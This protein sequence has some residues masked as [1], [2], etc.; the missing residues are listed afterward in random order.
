MST[1]TGNILS[2]TQRTGRPRTRPVPKERTVELCYGPTVSTAIEALAT[3]QARELA[4][5]GTRGDGK[6]IGVLGGMLEHARVHHSKGFPL[7]VKWI[8]V[9]DTLASHKLKTVP[10]LEHPLWG[11]MWKIED[12]GHLAKAIVNGR[13]IVRLHL[14][15][16][17]DQGAMDRVRMETCGVW[18]EEP[19]P[20]AVLV[21]SEGVNEMAWSIALTSQRL[22]THAHVAVMTL[23]YPDEDH[24]T[25][26][27]FRPGA[28]VCG[29]HPEDDTRLWIRIPPGERASADQRAEWAHALRDR[30]DIL[31]RLIDGQPGTIL[32]GPQVATGF[33]EDVHVATERL[34][35]VEGEPLL[36]GQDFGHTPA[37]IIGQVWRGERRVLA[38]LPCDRGGIAEHVANT[39]VPW[40][41]T[42]APWV[43]KRTG[44]LVG[45]Y[46]LAGETGEQTSIATNPVAVLEAM[47]PGLWFP[48][49]VKWVT[50]NHTL[51][52]ALHHHQAPGQVSLQIDPVEA[53][54]LVKALSGR[55][56]YALDR[57]GQVRRDLPKKPNHPWEDLGDAFI[58]WLWTL[59]SEVQP[60]GPLKVETAFS[61]APHQDRQEIPVESAFALTG[62]GR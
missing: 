59:T 37:T 5:Y 38:A 58:Y 14:F 19:A 12:S 7:P 10:S 47:L 48:G 13:E 33:R 51:I 23:N 34:V 32:L 61:L 36:L 8:G 62:G 22:P 26:T 24:W 25:W 43:L 21:K 20:S 60:P 3:G 4:I 54:P 1:L 52:S 9:T 42:H 44:Q 49:P 55:W 50:R 2:P 28:G 35:P 39:V 11:G 40:L 29:W 17:E 16:I 30:P 41:Q 27:R 15:G 31:R 45:C 6:T 18:F 46:D 56:H 57:Q 53:V